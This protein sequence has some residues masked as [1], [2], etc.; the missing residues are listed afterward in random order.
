MGNIREAVDLYLEPNPAQVPDDASHEAVHPEVIGGVA[1]PQPKRTAAV[2][3]AARTMHGRCR[4]TPQA[5]PLPARGGWD[6]R[7]PNKV[8]AS[9]DDFPRY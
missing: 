9:G 8:R 2:S 4:V 6:T 5:L 7:G 1:Q 3:A